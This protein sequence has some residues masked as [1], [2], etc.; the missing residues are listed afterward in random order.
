M[1]EVPLT[2]GKIALVD[3]EDFENIN[4][5]KWHVS[6]GGYVVRSTPRILGKQQS[7]Y[8]HKFILT[9]PNEVDHINHNTLDNRRANLR[10]ATR[11][12]NMAN[13]RPRPGTSKYK[14]VYWHKRDMQWCAQL[15]VNYKT[16]YWKRFNSEKEA[17]IA[18]N[19]A[20]L[21]YFGEF[22]VMNEVV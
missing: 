16:V 18:Y 19:K 13:T 17:A 2:G 12:Q 5:H 20:A 14:G 22:A 10:I 9:S 11:S 15:R 3:D 21:W 1:K 6:R 7:I 4:Q 8:L